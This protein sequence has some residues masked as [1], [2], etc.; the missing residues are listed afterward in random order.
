MIKNLYNYREFLKTSVLK[1]FRGKYKKSFLG[2]LWSFINPLLQLFIYS[3]VFSFI[4]KNDIDNYA[5]FLVVALIPWTFFNTTIIQSTS[6]IVTNGGILKKI[7]FPREIL[8]ISVVTSN[9]FNFLI[10]CLI[11]VVALIVSGVGISVHILLFPV[12]LLIKY[13]L[14]IGCA[15]V[16]SS[17]TVFIRDLEYFINVL[18]MLLFY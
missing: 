4:M 12:V 13:V 7:Y 5:I 1:E 16:L 9:L 17:I 15:Y 10:S 8:P 2:V 11:I 18:M 6:T 3:V 14:L